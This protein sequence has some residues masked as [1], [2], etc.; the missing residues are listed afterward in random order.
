MNEYDLLHAGCV[1]CNDFPHYIC[2]LCKSLICKYC[3]NDHKCKKGNLV[4]YY[5]SKE[6]QT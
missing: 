2:S 6:G 3:Q 4:K 5:S 1:H